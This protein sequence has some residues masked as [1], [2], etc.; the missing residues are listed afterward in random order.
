[1]LIETDNPRELTDMLQPYMDLLS[2]D[3]HAV[4]EQASYEALVKTFREKTA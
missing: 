2:W 1:M 3:V 4:T